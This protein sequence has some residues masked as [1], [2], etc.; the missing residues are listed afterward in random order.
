MKLPLSWI[1]DFVDIDI[2]I[3]EVASKLTLAGL[4]V[5]E[6]QYV[7]WKM[8]DTTGSNHEFKTSGLEWSPDKLI[9]AEV[10][11]VMPHPAADRLVLCKLDDGEEEHIVLTGAP[12][13][14]VYKGKGKLPSPLK[15]AYAREGAM[16]YDGHSEGQVLTKL[17]ENKDPRC[18]L[19]LDDLLRKGIRHLGRTRRCHHYW[20]MMR[21]K[22]L[23]WQITWVT[24]Y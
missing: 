20:M 11:E 21:Q 1:K 22:A 14:F 15:V 12:N 17:K 10:S 19:I 3:E 4:E 2:S 16:I 24:Q 18:G 8:P 7:G 13:L 23:P 9:V 5:E 6:I